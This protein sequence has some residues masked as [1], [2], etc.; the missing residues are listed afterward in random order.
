MSE[1]ADHHGT[2]LCS[3]IAGGIRLAE[4]EMPPSRSLP[5]HAHGAG[6][7]VFV[8]EGAYL[9]SWS[10]TGTELGPGSVLYRPPD[11]PHSNRFGDQAV[12]ALTLSYPVE[13]LQAIGRGRVPRNI[14]PLLADLRRQIRNELWCDDPAAAPALEG[15]ALLVLARV[16]RARHPKRPEWL[17]AAAEF[18]A[19]HHR[20][21]ISLSRV[22]Q[23][24]GVHRA[25]L[26]AGFRRY[27]GCSVGDMIT[28]CRVQSA[29]DAIRAN[30]RPLSEI[31]QACGFCDQ[32]HMGRH[33]RRATGK[34]PSLLRR[35]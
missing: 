33:V 9:E 6:Q 17:D 2:E 22:A 5:R 7:L 26:S 31:A 11:T 15:L 23:Q 8:L 20:E 3:R 34:T 14:G 27:L 25:T 32:A 28:A 29:I 13:R 10:R 18:V 21:P 16:D 19:R 30:S 24:V 4:V 1:C 12:L 35:S